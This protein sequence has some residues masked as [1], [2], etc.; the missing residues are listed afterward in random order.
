MRNAAAT[1]SRDESRASTSN[2]AATAMTH[3]S[4][5]T[6]VEG[7]SIQGRLAGPSSVHATAARIPVRFRIAFRAI[8]T[9]RIGRDR[10][11][12][13][14][15]GRRRLSRGAPGLIYPGGSERMATFG[16]KGQRD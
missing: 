5:V 7:R 3:T 11:R 8:G 14:Y 13:S 10:W 15:A 6:V 16:C 1:T 2:T 4:A 12:N 9:C